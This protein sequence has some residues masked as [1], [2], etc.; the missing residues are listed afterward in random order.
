MSDATPLD[1]HA[2]IDRP[3]QTSTWT[4]V[5]RQLAR[6]L[7]LLASRLLTPHGLQSA[8]VRRA[9]WRRGVAAQP[10][11]FY[12]STTDPEDLPE[13]GPPAPCAGV[14]FD[15]AAH[16]HYLREVFPKYQ[17]EFAGLLVERPPD[18]LE[19]PR[20]FLRND[21][22][23]DIDAL[24]YWGFIREHRPQRIVELGSGY[25]TMLAAEAVAANGVGRVTAID[26]YPREFVR[27]N[28]LG[29]QVMTTPA[30]TLSAEIMQ[31]LDVDDIAFVDSSHVVRQG[32]DVTWFFLNVLPL[33]RPG[34]IVH[35]HDVHLPFEYPRELV[36]QRNVYWTEQYLLQ[37]YLIQNTR[38]HVLFGSRYAVHAL[39]D[40]TASAFPQ[41]DRLHGASFWFRV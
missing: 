11:G 27:R 9:L 20:F 23:K 15:H 22:F 14:D 5:K 2:A 41:A 12:C 35:V 31:S 28:D 8:A 3:P 10:K 16:E 24:A 19:R 6:W 37:A 29:I 32:G 25:S 13:A 34:V 39:P 26:P 38:A 36:T 4:T 1:P 21:A 30:E 33:L 40:E 18:W 7:G 17:D